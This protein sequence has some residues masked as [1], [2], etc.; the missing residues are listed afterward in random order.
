[1]IHIDP[2]SL[3]SWLEASSAHID[4]RGSR[5]TIQELKLEELPTVVVV[6][7]NWMVRREYLPK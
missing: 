2:S 4:L 3:E 6:I 1:V 5:C 7:S